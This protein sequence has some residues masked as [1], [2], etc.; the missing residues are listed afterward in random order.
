[1]LTILLFN[2]KLFFR[3]DLM[4][5]LDKKILKIHNYIYANEGLSNSETL[6]EFLKIFYCKII[7]EKNNN[8][9]SIKNSNEDI[10]L[11]MHELFDVLKKKIGNFI[12]SKEKI[13]LK[14]ETIIYIVNELRNVQLDS[15]SA[16]TKGH[17]LQRIIDRSYRE[18]K[19]QFFT[20]IPVVNFI[21]K[22]IEPQKTEL[23]CDP[24]CGTGGFM[25][26]ALEYINN[27]EKIDNDTL[28]NVYF[29]DI[30][31][32]LIKLVAMRMMFEFSNC[33]SNYQV[34]DSISNEINQ[35]FDYVLT[36]PPFGTQGKISD[37]KILK[38][39]N[40]SMNGKKKLNAQ[41]PDILFV[42]KVIKI[43]KENGR[44]A[45]ILPDGDF[46]NPSQEYFRKYLINN[47][48]ID[49][50][51]SLPDGTFI[52]YGTG[53][54]SSILFFS[55][56]SEKELNNQKK[57]NYKVFF[58]KINKLGYSFSK[59][60][61][62][63]YDKN[64]NIDEDYSSVLKSFKEKQYND[65]CYLV[66]IHDI[67]NNKYNLSESFYSP[68]YNN[69]I[70]NI[71]KQS[72]ERLKDIVEFNYSKN[73]FIEDKIYKY[74]EISDINSY[75]GEIINCTDILGEDLPSRA[76]YRLETNDIIVATSGNAIGTKKQTKAIITDN[77]NNCICTNGFTVMKSKKYSP[78]FLLNFFNSDVF[79]KQVLKYKYG[80]A[81]PCIG[82][83]EF[84]N[85]LVPIPD[86][87]EI[88]KIET[89]IK[90]SIKLREEAFNLM[91]S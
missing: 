41:V 34:Q 21:V 67:I 54:K 49:A 89:K 59:H 1:M 39:Y 28:K 30:S 64:G 76:S 91:N 5:L 84:E 37:S 11:I 83:E 71:K 57:N 44:A 81:I 90:K 66:G 31:K 25:F 35:K 70:E 33:D 20:P 40:L 69:I 36:N 72:Y 4:E 51:I 38:E 80:T 17:I 26:S 15:I 46:E 62:D 58:G 75:T 61:K 77:Y 23:G 43:L 19:G 13:N 73:K 56:L 45:I 74:I 22:M 50:I 32:S 88:K 87:N 79:L 65:N 48:K 9:L 52:P 85:I 60:S 2:V 47:V 63:L 42:E 7:D 55:K 10:I 8:L 78:Y 16:D 24:A 53:V 18:S 14:K 68:Q 82:R 6:N 3:G 29:Y 86:N 12:D 27:N